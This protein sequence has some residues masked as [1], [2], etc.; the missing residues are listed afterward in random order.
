M[1]YLL[2][3]GYLIRFSVHMISI[4]SQSLPVHGKIPDLQGPSISVSTENRMSPQQLESPHM[5]KKKG[6]YTSKLAYISN[7]LKEN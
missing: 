5:E 2:S 3:I 6:W 1:R 7:I 4:T